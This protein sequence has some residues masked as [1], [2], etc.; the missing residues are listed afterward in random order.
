MSVRNQL[1]LL[2]GGL[3]ARRTGEPAPGH[4]ASSN[5]ALSATRDFLDRSRV[6]AALIF[7]ITVVAI[8]L[9]S[10]AGMT[11]SNVA[12]LPNQLATA[13]VNASAAFT[14]ESAEKTRAA[15][16]QFLDRVPP[17][18]R[19]DP[20]PFRRFE[21][22]ARALLARLD[23]YEQAHIP[24]PATSS[25]PLSASNSSARPNSVPSGSQL[26]AL[27][28]QPSAPTSPLAHPATAIATRRA[29]FTA[30]AE[31]FNAAGPYHATP[32]DI[33]ALFA[34][35]DAKAR[36]AV[37]DNGLATLRDI[38]AQGVTD[39]ALAGRTAGSAV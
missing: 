25:T 33:A 37:F 4:R 24:P 9:I 27:S 22:A 14:Y 26:S 32:E 16:E 6:V 23:A 15:R 35:G 7:V 18:S 28:S 5:A 21:P 38:Y 36:A 8:V 19:P 12:V 20:E 1:K 30:I 10:W 11:T 31:S 3:N 17:V 13:R 2:I 34:V 29:D 39:S